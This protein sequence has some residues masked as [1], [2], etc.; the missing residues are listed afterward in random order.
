MRKVTFASALLIAAT[1]NAYGIGIGTSSAEQQ[2]D[3]GACGKIIVG[4]TSVDDAEKMLNGKPATSGK[5][6]SRLYR[7]YQY[8]KE[9]GF[10]VSSLFSF[11]GNDATQYTCT[12]TYNHTG[13]ILNVN[14]QQVEVADLSSGV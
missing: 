2:F 1:T 10:G 13:T 5:Q 7:S 6:G 11:G 3:Y 4:E 12:L 8:T 14:M 9:S